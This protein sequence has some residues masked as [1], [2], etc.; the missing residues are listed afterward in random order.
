[1]GLGQ[2]SGQGLRSDFGDMCRSRGWVL[3]PMVGYG[4]WTRVGFGFWDRGQGRV[5][6]LGLESGFSAGSGFGT[7]VG[8]GFQNGGRGNILGSGSGFGTEVEVGI[9]V[10]FLD[11]VLVQVRVSR[12]ML[13]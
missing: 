12:P 9:G 5:S 8:A 2:V 11:G 13:G 10:G 7:R 3:V 1:M 4:F 6:G